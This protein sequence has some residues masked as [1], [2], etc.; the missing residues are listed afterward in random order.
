MDIFL[1]NNLIYQV[2][3]IPIIFFSIACYVVAFLA[4]F[5]KSKSLKFQKLNNSKWPRVS[6]QIP[7]FNDPVAIRC[8]EKC[9]KFDYPKNKFEI[10]VADDSNEEKTI[11]IL[12]DYLK[13]CPE[14]VKLIRRKDRKGFKA[15]ALNNALKHSSGKYIVVLDSDFIPKED[16]LRKIIYPF[17]SNQ[18]IGI[19][20][21]RCG[22]I[23]YE[24]NLI[25]RFSAMRYMIYYNCFMPINNRLGSVFFAGTG[26]AIKRS[27]LEKVGGWNEDSIQE[28]ADLSV[29]IINTGHKN[30]YLSNVK[31]EGEIPYDLE[32]IISQ[33][34]RLIYGTTRVFLDHWRKIF[35]R[36]FSTIQKFIIFFMTFWPFATVFMVGGAI[37]G[38]ISWMTAPQKSIS[39]NSLYPYL[40]ILVSS[41]G[42]ILLS[43]IGLYR[44]GKIKDIFKMIFVTYTLGVILSF[45]SAFAFTKALLK[46]KMAWKV[47]PKLGNNSILNMRH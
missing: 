33:Q 3:L 20:Q 47:A 11:K 39:I 34:N 8:I 17:L 32:G 10:I 19:V 30:I 44:D 28:D 35:S 24:Q 1:I 12:N 27:I 4:I 7:V 6:I 23:N 16:F 18:K 13:N 36:N 22:Y 25:S 29:K 5:T 41:S 40:W 46:R 42:F 14:K 2:F 21:S 45:F 38:Q 9:L 37:T 26:G 43:S 31:V 15:G